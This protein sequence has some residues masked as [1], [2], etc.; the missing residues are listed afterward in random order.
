MS[1]PRTGILAGGNWIVDQV[2]L[3]D[4]W[5]PQDALANITS[6]FSSNGGSPFNV[7]KN[8]ARL[9]ATF[10]LAAIGLVGDD[11]AGRFIRED[12][13]RHGTAT[14]RSCARRRPDRLRIRT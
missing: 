9:G 14:R 1:N 13:A 8:L 12:C 3:I 11:E 7:L 5:P 6:Q 4:R 2:K 10:P